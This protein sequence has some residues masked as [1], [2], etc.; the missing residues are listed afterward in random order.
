LKRPER[1]GEGVVSI[2]IDGTRVLRILVGRG[3]ARALRDVRLRA[4]ERLASRSR[5]GKS[6]DEDLVDLAIAAIEAESLDFQEG[7]A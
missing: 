3:Q 4:K 1:I 5:T 6:S 7:E 2:R